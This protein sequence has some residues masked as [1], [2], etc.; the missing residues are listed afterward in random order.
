MAVDWDWE[1]VVFDHVKLVVRDAAASVAFYK[2]LL[3][4][5]EIPPLWE[6]ERGAQFANLVVVGRDDPGGPIH[7][8]FVARSRGEVDAFHRA[9]L[10]AGGRDHGA[11]GVREKYSSDA[12][13]R[14]YA[15]F[16][17]DPDG[18][19]VEAVVREF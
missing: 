4:T 12:G 10:E 1:R 2:A 18:N 15:A 6:N 13:G 17:L 5:L 19:N 16:V 9:G 8:A 3:A 14:Y 11:P 7:F